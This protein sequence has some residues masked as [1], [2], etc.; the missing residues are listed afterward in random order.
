MNEVDHSQFWEDIYLEDDVGW[1]L[2]GVT[3]IFES[4]SNELILGKVCVVGC[5]KGYDAIMFA[6]K[7]FEV[8][9][10]DFAPFAIN[11]VKKLAKKIGRYCSC[12]PG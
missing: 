4:L 6:E 3:P 8:T 2:N 10:V 9:A 5:G 1:D 11:A 7:G 12:N